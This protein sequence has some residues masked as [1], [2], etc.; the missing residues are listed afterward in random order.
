MPATPTTNPSDAQSPG[1]PT[2]TEPQAPR[3]PATAPEPAD[4]FTVTERVDSTWATGRCETVSVRNETAQSTDWQIELTLQGTLTD[5]WNAV[6]SA[7]SG[8]VTF[9]GVDWNRTLAPG[10]SAEFGF[11]VALSM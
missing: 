7:D 4:A 11:C 10:A 1:A 5:H 8:T 6:A 9:T 3:S 2:P